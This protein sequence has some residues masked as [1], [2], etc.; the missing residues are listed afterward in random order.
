MGN[1]L[2]LETDRVRRN[3]AS[4][5]NRRIDASTRANLRRYADRPRLFIDRRIRRLQREWDI[6]RVLETNASTLALTGIVLGLT[7]NRRWL[8]LSGAVTG[9][10]LLHAVQGWC[11]P[12]PVLRRLGVRTRSEIDRELLALRYVRGDFGDQLPSPRARRRIGALVG[13]E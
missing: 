8:L 4:R 10:L 6:E 3:T 12:V 2:A 11:P 5:I 7:V 9:F 1:G 13:E